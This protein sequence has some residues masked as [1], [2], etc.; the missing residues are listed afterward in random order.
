MPLKG[1]PASIPKTQFSAERALIPL[2]EIS[3]KPHYFGS[4]AHETVRE[5]LVSQLKDLGLEVEVQQGFVLDP[6]IGNLDKPKN[7]VARLKGS[8]NGKS[9]V[10]LTHYDSALV[11]SFGASDAGSGLVTILESLRAYKASGE[12]PKND[13]IILFSDTEEINLDG[14]NLFVSEHRW[15]KNVGFVINFEARGS[16][17]PSVMILESNHGNANLINAFI[18]ANPQ[19]PVASSLMYSVY[20]M[21]PNSTDSTIFKE[22]SDIDSFFFAFIDDHFD[23]HTANDTFENLDRNTLQHQGSY[24]LPLL[25]YFANA[26]LSKLKA[27]EDYVYVNFP[28]IKMISYPF[29]WILPMLIIALILFIG[30]VFF[31]IST[32]KLIGR[33][34]LKGFVSFFL[35]LIICGILGYFGWILLLKIYPQYNEIQHEFKYNGHSYIAF[36]VLL[37]LS[38]LFA[39]YRKYNKRVHTASLLVAPLFLWL[40]INTVVFIYLKG[41]AFFI[42]PVFFGLLSFWILLIKEKPNLLLLAFLAAP[43]IFIFSP[44]IQFFPV[45]LG[46]HMVV[47]SC[48]FTVLLFGLLLPVFGF[49]RKKGFLS[50]VCFLAALGFFIKAHLNSDFSETQQKPNSLVFYQDEDTR[51]A[52]WLTYDKILD[53]WTRNYLGKNPERA[54]KIMDNASPSKYNSQFT[55]AAETSVKPVPVFEIHLKKDTISEENRTVTFTLIP[56]R[57]VN[58]INLYVNPKIEFTSLKFNGKSFPKNVNGIVKRN[59][60]N[61]L[62]LRYYVID[63]DSLEV[64]YAVAKNT[65]VKFKAI[66]YSYDL[67]DNS[68]FTIPERPKNTM[69]KPFIVNDAVIIKKSFTIEKM[70]KAKKDT[71][72]NFNDANLRPQ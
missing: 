38:I 19:Y 65:F 3:K 40:V 59:Q 26:D 66:E 4:E 1:E 61:N 16:G 55:Y 67:L 34:I 21:L 18:E 15:A 68:L 46:S 52:Y 53:D 50:V 69:T 32:R 35:P 72:L 24:L 49:Y 47:I 8:G 9:L 64:S 56:K 37:T 6:K 27:E 60:N 44:L 42:I 71:L 11:P 14:A 54:S 57:K 45:A 39:F 5:Y 2:K 63:Q 28:F 51:Q 13:I 23:Y 48:V 22:K 25:H 33:K 43:A 70:I 36:F 12:I 20:K 10:L 58:Q 31:G 41:A 17:G 29:S 62:L 7:I 30:L